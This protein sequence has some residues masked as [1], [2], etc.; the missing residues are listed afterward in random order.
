MRE[1]PKVQV[2]MIKSTEHPSGIG[3]PCVPPVAPFIG[4]ACFAATGKRFRSLPL[5]LKNPA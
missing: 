3:E 4:N 5:E 2:H 1:M